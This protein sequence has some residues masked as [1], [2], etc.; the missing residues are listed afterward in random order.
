MNSK[1]MMNF[2]KITPSSYSERF[3]K[4]ADVY[5]KYMITGSQMYIN[6]IISYLNNKIIQTPI[7]ISTERYIAISLE[8]FHILEKVTSFGD[9]YEDNIMEPVFS[10]LDEIIKGNDDLIESHYFSHYFNLYIE[11]K[12]IKE[13]YLKEIPIEKI[14]NFSSLPIEEK[15]KY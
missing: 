15:K 1:I 6:N 7:E 8:I 2:D 10:F 11:Y 5:I 12:Y 4:Y 3:E 9:M 14:L 13:I